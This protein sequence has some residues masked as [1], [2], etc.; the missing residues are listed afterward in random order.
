M[1]LTMKLFPGGNTSQGFYSCFPS[2]MEEKTRLFLLKGGPGVGKSSMM[3]R[4]AHALDDAG[5]DYEL[6]PCSSDPNSLDAVCAPSLGITIMDATAPHHYDPAVPGA[7]DTLVSLG[8]DLDEA[9]L[10]RDRERISDLFS[11]VS[12]RFR[13]AYCYLSAAAQVRRAV[14]SAQPDPVRAAQMARILASRYL[15]DVRHAGH[16]RDLF[17][18]AYTPL[19]YVSFLKEL[20]KTQSVSLISPFGHTASPLLERLL[21]E[22]TLRGHDAVALRDPLQ[23]EFL[24]HLYVPSAGLLFT[25]DEAED[26]AEQVDA[27]ALYGRSAAMRPHDEETCAS[28]IAQAI[29][30]LKAAMALHDDLESYYIAA[31]DFSRWQ[32][33]LDALLEEI[34]SSAR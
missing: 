20:P 14:E 22:A 3:K 21:E 7:R 4:V 19:G 23:P 6:F 28:L 27:G 15:P 17:G 16:K 34:F 5:L 10:Q 33:T 1:A 11:A 31:M 26:S 8:D 30:E 12:E 2:V 29:A 13:R 18:A 9:S 24:A 32:K 25:T